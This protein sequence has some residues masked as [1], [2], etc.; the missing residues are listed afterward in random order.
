MKCDFPGLKAGV[1][2]NTDW[3]RVHI[4]AWEVIDWYSWRPCRV[5]EINL[6]NETGSLDCELINVC[7]KICYMHFSMYMTQKGRSLTN[8]IHRVMWRRGNPCI[9]FSYDYSVFSQCVFNSK[10]QLSVKMVDNKRGADL[11]CSLCPCVKAKLCLPV[12]GALIDGRQRNC[13]IIHC[14]IRPSGHLR[15]AGEREEEHRDR[16]RIIQFINA[17]KHMQEG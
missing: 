16:I 14:W 1:L 11:G 13:W 12:G 5:M 2:E 4:S 7:H 15:K 6:N 17:P 9:H 8:K 10:K 3:A